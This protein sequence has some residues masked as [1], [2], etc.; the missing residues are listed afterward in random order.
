MH[1]WYGR[2]VHVLNNHL[3]L[4]PQKKTKKDWT[5]PLFQKRS[6]SQKKVQKK[7][8]KMQLTYAKEGQCPLA[9]CQDWFVHLHALAF[10]FAKTLSGKINPKKRNCKFRLST[11]LGRSNFIVQSPEK[12]LF[13]SIKRAKGDKKCKSAKKYSWEWSFSLDWFKKHKESCGCGVGKEYH[14]IRKRC[15]IK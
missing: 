1:F 5:K 2:M 7:H 12:N 14:K 4:F 9:S 10:D 13:F 6:N 15:D 8:R 11:I 3:Y